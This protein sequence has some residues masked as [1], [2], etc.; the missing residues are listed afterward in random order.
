MI[1]YVE[2]EPD[3][4]EIFEFIMEDLGLAVTCYLNHS[5]LHAKAGDI[6]FCDKY[7]VGELVRVPGVIYL[8][9]SGD[10]M[11]GALSKP[12]RVEEIKAALGF[13]K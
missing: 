3:L 7:G 6:V 1:Y 8:E 5:Q 9:I 11:I 12:Y 4:H 10:P 2:D 13:W